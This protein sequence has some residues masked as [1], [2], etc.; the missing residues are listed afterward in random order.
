LSQRA[1]LGAPAQRSGSADD[2]DGGTG[3]GRFGATEDELGGSSTLDDSMTSEEEE[4]SITSEEDVSIISS[5]EED[6]IGLGI[7][8]TSE[9]AQKNVAKMATENAE[10]KR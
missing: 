1:A 5:D 3:L 2:E 8:L 6:N 10:I 7:S 9:H 4:D